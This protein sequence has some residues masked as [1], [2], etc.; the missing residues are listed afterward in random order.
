MVYRLSTSASYSA[1]LAFYVLTFL[2][3]LFGRYVT[4]LQS[5]CTGYLNAVLDVQ[6]Q[7][8]MWLLR[9]NYLFMRLCLSHFTSSHW[10]ISFVVH[11]RLLI[12]LLW[13]ENSRRVGFDF[14][15]RSRA[16]LTHFH[17][18][19]ISSW[20]ATETII[21]SQSYPKFFDSCYFTFWSIS[22]LTQ[23]TSWQFLPS[24]TWISSTSMF[25]KKKSD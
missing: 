23:P 12:V 20:T 7:S 17:Y 6:W 1:I 2:N 8:V 16:T 19:D 15:T 21:P 13:S 11:L 9:C 22:S 10:V 3:A 14:E 18:S 4:P 24:S 5:C 25:C